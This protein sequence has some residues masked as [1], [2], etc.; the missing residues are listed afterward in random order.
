MW[1]W[2]RQLRGCKEEMSGECYIL[3]LNIYLQRKVSF[4]IQV[5]LKVS[6]LAW[7]LLRDRLPTKAYLVSRG[8]LSSEAHYYVFGCGAVESAQHLF[9][10]CSIFGSLW[11]LV[12]GGH[13]AVALL[14]NS[15]GW[16]AF[17]L[18][19]T[20]ETLDCSEGS[21]LISTYVG[22]DQDFFI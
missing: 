12:T 4:D 7:R 8:I 15:S 6:I 17:G 10:S 9:L 21:K 18:C 1:V 16:L 5:P 13:K 14:C 22:Q 20:S 2:Q 3:L 19:G 11:A